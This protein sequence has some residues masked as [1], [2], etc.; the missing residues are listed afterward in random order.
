MHEQVELRD[1]S[2]VAPQ[3]EAIVAAVATRL[4]SLLPRAEVHH[5][6]ATSLPLG[7]TKGDVD[8]NV[9]VDAAEFGD[10][11]A[12]LRDRYDVAQPENW[13]DGF[14]SFVTRAY[15]LPLGLQ[16]TAIGTPDDFLLELRDRMRA[17]PALARRYDEIKREAAAG[18]PAAYWE[19]KN[20]FIAGLLGR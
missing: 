4:A 13:T 11:V 5:I 17:E 2:E 14:A 16:V 3:A 8:V 19:A 18:G 10:A 6:G 20:S 9:R 1:V 12:A 7:R 15:E